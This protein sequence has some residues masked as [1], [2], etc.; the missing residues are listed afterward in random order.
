MRGD[1]GDLR[2]GPKTKTDPIVVCVPV[3]LPGEDRHWE[4]LGQRQQIKRYCGRK[5]LKD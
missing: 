5:I 1:F 3:T 2:Q 4:G